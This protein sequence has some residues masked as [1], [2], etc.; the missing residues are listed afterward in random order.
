[1]F[2]KLLSTASFLK[3]KPHLA[4]RYIVPDTK[5]MNSIY[6][7]TR[8][9]LFF[10]DFFV[11]K[12]KLKKNKLN[13]SF[14]KLD[15][16][17][18]NG[19]LA[20]KNLKKTTLMNK[21]LKTCDTHLKKINWKKIRKEAK[22]PFL[23][24]HNVD[25]R[26]KENFDILNFALDKDVIGKVSN[27]FNQ[28]PV[29]H[30]AGIWLSPNDGFDGPERSQQFHLDG[31]GKQMQVIIPLDDIC[32]N[33]GP[34]TIISKKE[35]KHILKGLKNKNVRKILGSVKTNQKFKDEFL[36]NYKPKVIPLTGERG[37]MFFIDTYNCFH[38]GS[39]NAKHPR[40]LLHIYYIT[41]Q[42]ISYPLWGTKKDL[43]DKLNIKFKEE[44]KNNLVP[45]VLYHYLTQMQNGAD[46]SY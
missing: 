1:M 23:L 32:K 35:S 38:Y 27:Y 46:L 13:F 10:K 42:H 5:F 40:L 37:D 20:Y 43:Y 41:S 39:R 9:I 16:F 36:M 28:I 19:Y 30:S 14:N 22:K 11:R 31:G 21:V 29:L 7:T 2:K 34:F 44:Y 17:N 24:E 8:Q 15:D 12:N 3:N 6:T 25:L 4:Q 45:Q 33:S 26:K 18:A